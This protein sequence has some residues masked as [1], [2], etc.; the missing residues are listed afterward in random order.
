[1]YSLGFSSCSQSR[2]RDCISEILF[3]HSGFIPPF[4]EKFTDYEISHNLFYT[5]DGYW[6][7]QNNLPITFKLDQCPNIFIPKL[8]TSFQF[9]T[10]AGEPSLLFRP[11]QSKS[12]VLISQNWRGSDLNIRILGQISNISGPSCCYHSF[13]FYFIRLAFIFL[14]IPDLEEHKSKTLVKKRPT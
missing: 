7:F 1:M 14:S 12:N 3:S 8:G 11:Y 4:S 9:Q 2:Y 5:A 6:S 10:Q 13:S